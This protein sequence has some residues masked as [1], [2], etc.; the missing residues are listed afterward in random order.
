MITV[1]IYIERALVFKKTYNS[2]IYLVP[3]VSKKF[4]S[5]KYVIRK[6][7]YCIYLKNWCILKNYNL[8]APINLKSD[9]SSTESED[10][11]DVPIWKNGSE[12]LRIKKAY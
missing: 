6:I 4:E 8:V 11:D 3:K 10:E 9:F 2:A 12:K 7:L 1:I 5:E